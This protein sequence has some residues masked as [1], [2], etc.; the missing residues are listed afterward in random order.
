M[1]NGG[2]GEKRGR[3]RRQLEEEA[4]FRNTNLTEQNDEKEFDMKDRRGK[5]SPKGR[6]GR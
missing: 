4:L 6:E 1:G 5:E 3:S 2:K